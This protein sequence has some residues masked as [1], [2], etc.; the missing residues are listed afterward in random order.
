M[1]FPITINHDNNLESLAILQKYTSRQTR[2]DKTHARYAS[3]MMAIDHLIVNFEEVVKIDTSYQGFEE[4]NEGDFDTSTYSKCITD[5]KDFLL[6]A[7]LFDGT[8]GST[9]C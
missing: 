1:N 4:R 2:K 9:P 6:A 5:K 7:C 8:F 3:A